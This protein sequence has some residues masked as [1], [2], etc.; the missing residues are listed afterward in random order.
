MPLDGL[1]L[2][3]NAVPALSQDQ[4]HIHVDC[5]R[6]DVL[7]ALRDH[8]GEIGPDWSPLS[9][10]LA[11]R[12]YL[13]MRVPGERLEDSSPFKLLAERVPGAKREMGLHTLAVVAA[14]ADGG[15]G[16]IILDRPVSPETGD[17]GHGTELLDRACGLSGRHPSVPGTLHHG[18]I[19]YPERV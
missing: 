17:T 1:D 4:L 2:V 11:G 19:P 13:A 3:A 7:D 6:G 10:P 12:H 14:G 18:L 15:P 9:I 16:F 5:L 8:A